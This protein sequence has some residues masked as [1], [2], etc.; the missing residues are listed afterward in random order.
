[1]NYNNDVITSCAKSFTDYTDV[2]QTVLP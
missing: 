2:S 1:L